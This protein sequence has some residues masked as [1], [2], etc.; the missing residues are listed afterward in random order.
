[1][2]MPS[3]HVEVR[4]QVA[5][6]G[7]LLPQ[8]GPGNQTEM[9]RLSSKHLYSQSRLN[10]L[11]LSFKTGSFPEA[12]TH[13]LAGLADQKALGCFLSLLSVLGL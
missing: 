7:S 13:Q 12:A 5:G 4:E 10:G 8:M 3:A 2:S 1:M 9:A 11:V 6:V